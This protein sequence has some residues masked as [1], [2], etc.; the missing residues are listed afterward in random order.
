MVVEQYVPR[1]CGTMSHERL[2]GAFLGQY[3]A[4]SPCNRNCWRLVRLR[5]FLL[6]AT[7][8]L[9][10]R[11]AAAGQQCHP[12]TG[13]IGRNTG[14]FA[15]VRVDAAGYRNSSYVGDFQG[16]APMVS[17][18]HRRVSAVAL[19]PA[20]RLTRNGRT[21]YGLGDLALAVRVPVPAFASKSS[22][23]G[24]GLSMTLPTGKSSADLGMGHV[25]LMP[26]FW[27]IHQRDRVQLL[28]TLGFARAL[29]GASS[30]SHAHGP[31]P[32][33]NPMNLAEIDASLYSYVRVHD[34][35][36][37]KLGMFGAMPVGTVNPQG[38]TRV[39]AAS[40]LA[41][42]VRGFELSAELQAPL[43]GSPFLARGVLQ[44]GYRF[45]LERRGKPRRAR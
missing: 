14:L 40:G 1:P 42:T 18:N 9:V 41:V 35:V 21:G 6:V 10:A 12:L 7:V 45:E 30:S 23:A 16:L 5:W 31:R 22:S 38:R 17:L 13:D 3:A 20:Y 37:L 4:V 8:L 19:L 29:V 33:V 44:V 15:G 39:V 28:G 11:G 25:M 27:F 34:R 36:W 26:E 2:L 43:T 24:F 32:I